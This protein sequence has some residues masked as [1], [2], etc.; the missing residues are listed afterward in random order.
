VQATV[1]RR[2]AGVVDPGSTRAGA[3]GEVE[4]E[5]V[6][7]SKMTDGRRLLRFYYGD[8]SRARAGR[9]SSE[10]GQAYR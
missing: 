5:T 2:S 1:A 9:D 4:M 10:L 8:W 3:D 7:E 6:H